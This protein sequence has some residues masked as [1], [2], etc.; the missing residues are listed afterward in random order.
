M[1]D[2]LDNYHLIKTIESDNSTIEIYDV[3]NKEI[4]KERQNLINL[5]DTIFE[6]SNS[7]TSRGIN[8]DDWFYSKSQIKDMKQDSNYR[9]I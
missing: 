6:I 9:F 2:T 8:T 3:A 5:Y 1:K 7:L 4:N